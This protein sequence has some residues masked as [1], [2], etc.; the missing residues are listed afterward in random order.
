MDPLD[1][2]VPKQNQ[3]L[4]ERGRVLLHG[5]ADDV[6]DR[7]HDCADVVDV[8]ERAPTFLVRHDD[9]RAALVHAQHAV[10]VVREPEQSLALIR[11]HVRR[12]QIRAGANRIGDLIVDV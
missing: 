4:V 1:R 5:N 10:S 6:V 9:V 3:D 11:D 2:S 8:N 12:R 7:H